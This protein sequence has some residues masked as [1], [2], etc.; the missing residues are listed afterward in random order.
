M[1][2][3][4]RLLSVSRNHTGLALLLA[5]FMGSWGWIGCGQKEQQTPADEPSPNA[6]K[7]GNPQPL[8]VEQEEQ[9]AAE[10]YYRRGRSY[11]QNGQYEEAV[12]EFSRAVHL[13]PD[14]ALAL[15]QIGLAYTL[16]LRPGE[17]IPY[18][19]RAIAQAPEM[20][21]SSCISEKP[22]WTCAIMPQPR[23]PIDA[24]LS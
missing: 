11:L 12:G 8:K 3:Q 6:Q 1:A 10:V 20:G 5:L 23:W 21:F 2:Y 13:K 14:F 15:D 17:A 22:T 7:E 4:Q 19:K 9:I 16:Q 18:Y 24:L